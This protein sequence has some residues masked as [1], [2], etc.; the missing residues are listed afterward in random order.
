MTIHA[1]SSA[2][3]D[4]PVELQPPTDVAPPAETEPVNPVQA[5]ADLEAAIA[6]HEPGD[7]IV[8]APITIEKLP[9]HLL[10]LR[11]KA[12]EAEYRYN[13]AAESAKYAKKSW[14]A[15]REAFESAFDAEVRRDKDGKSPGLPFDGVHMS[16]TPQPEPPQ[17]VTE[18][19]VSIMPVGIREKILGPLGDEER[20]VCLDHGIEA[21]TDNLYIYNTVVDP[22]ST[23]AEASEAIVC[24]IC[25]KTILPAV[26]IDAPVEPVAESTE[27][28]PEY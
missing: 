28:T 24:A 15:A 4:T 1:F 13:S 11:S 23:I 10:T 22:A 21:N 27:P 12:S 3:P 8:Q 5:A 9:E 16:D 7:T 2:P 25:G 18:V 26:T 19:A 6:E 14:E 20:T 17:E